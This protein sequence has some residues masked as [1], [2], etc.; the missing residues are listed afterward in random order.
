VILHRYVDEDAYAYEMFADKYND[1][2]RSYYFDFQLALEDYKM[3]I[4]DACID[5]QSH[6]SILFKD[7]EN[8]G[9]I[10]NTDIHIRNNTLMHII[11]P[12]AN[13]DPESWN[14]KI[15]YIFASYAHKDREIVLPILDEM[16]KYC[17]V[18]YDEY[19]PEGT[20]WNDEIKKNIQNCGVFVSFISSA[21]KASSVNC[22]EEE[23][24]YAIEKKKQCMPIYIE[25]VELE[26]KLKKFQ[27]IFWFDKKSKNIL[28][29]KLKNHLCWGSAC[30][31]LCWI[32]LS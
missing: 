18:W 16:E 30:F 22:I 10:R 32:L 29:A 26:A 4:E 23:L 9:A 3:A 31:R 25:D 27:A 11:E 14:E 6:S 28:H 8:T 21:Y 7:D 15:D 5:I 17:R 2:Y 13:E 20:I 24:N 12:Y 19:I 1:D